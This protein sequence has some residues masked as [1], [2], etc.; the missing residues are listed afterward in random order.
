MVQNGSPIDAQDF[1]QSTA[2]NYALIFSKNAIA[3]YLIQ[4]GANIET[5]DHTGDTPLMDSVSH[6]SH[7]SVDL[8]LRLPYNYLLVNNKGSTVLHYAAKYPNASML[9]VLARH[10]LSGLDP[11]AK[12]K[13][14]LTA[15]EIFEQT[16][17]KSDALVQAFN[18]LLR[19]IL[20]RNGN[21]GPWEEGDG[22]GV[23]VFHDAVEEVEM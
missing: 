16:E 21:F 8:L 23:E 2:L 14:G 3:E 17:A 9:Q 1:F 6:Y 10:D 18:E 5:L 11:L 13:D 19:S 15:M 7:D 20:Q 22:E 12:Q 4:M